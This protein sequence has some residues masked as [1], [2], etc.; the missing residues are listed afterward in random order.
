MAFNPI[1]YHLVSFV[2]GLV[3]KL[4]CKKVGDNVGGIRTSGPL[5]GSVPDT[6]PR[7]ILY[8]NIGAPLVLLL[9]V[10]E[11]CGC[12][13]VPLR[14]TEEDPCGGEDRCQYYQDQK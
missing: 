7:Y 6:L 3:Q 8:L 1:Y 13:C 12:E 14:V 10:L 11:T 5:A 4:R 9:A 2:F